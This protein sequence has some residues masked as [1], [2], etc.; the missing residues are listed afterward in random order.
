LRGDQ[1]RIGKEE[2]SSAEGLTT[3][4]KTKL[5]RKDIAPHADG[6]SSEE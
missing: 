4:R 6:C 2:K 1:R 5:G 3:N